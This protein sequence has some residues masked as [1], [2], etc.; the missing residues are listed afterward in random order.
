VSAGLYAT[1]DEQHFIIRTDAW[2]GPC[3]GNLARWEHA[4]PLDGGLAIDGDVFCKTLRD[5]KREVEA[6]LNAR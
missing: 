1:A 3:G 2:E 5:A 6:L 4:I